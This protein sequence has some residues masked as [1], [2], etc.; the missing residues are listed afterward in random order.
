MNR[1][2]PCLVTLLGVA[3]VLCACSGLPTQKNVGGGGNGTANVT[4]TVFDAAPAGIDFVNFNLPLTAVT[5]KPQTGADVSV[6]APASP[7]VLE[8]THLQSDSSLLGTF[9][10]AAGTYTAANIVVGSPSALFAN[11]SGAAVAGC[12][13]Q[14]V[15]RLTGGAGQITVTFSPPLVLSGNQNIALGL[16][17]NLQNAITNQNGVTIDLINQTNVVTVPTL[18]RT[19][20][21][22]GTVDSVEDFV[23]VVKTVSGSTITLQN[24]AGVTL[25]GT[26]G[27][28]TT[29]DAPPGGSSACGGVFNLACVAVGQTLS[30]DATISTTGAV[31]IINVDFLDL[32]AV[33]EIEGTIFST[34]TPGTFL[35]AVDHKTLAANS[36]NATVLGPAGSG[37]ILNVILSTGGVT[38]AIDNNKLPVSSSLGFLDSTDLITGQRIMARVKS[39]ATG[40][41]LNVTSDRMVLRF[42]RFT[43]T[44]GTVAGNLFAL[45]TPPAFL[46]LN[47]PPEVLTF[48]PQTTFDGIT[49]ISGLS[50]VTTPVSIRALFLNPGKTSQ[51]LLAAKVRKR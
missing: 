43:G 15:C 4:I 1:K 8:I 24:D 48:V 32:P 17:F 16:D 2:N 25:S 44:P 33:D 51:P 42:S 5:F 37:T 12:L 40:T 3:F 27:S 6:F 35:M 28:S 34:S 11:S 41:V 9:Q 47:T 30:V 23:G 50:G 10:V 13:N 21:A 31:S 29:F 26:T 22:S 46:S 19:G 36:A 20:Q 38:F 39:V 7:L 49:D 45:Q 14:T 18:P